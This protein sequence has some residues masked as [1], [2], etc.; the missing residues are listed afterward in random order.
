MGGG[1]LK[2]IHFQPQ[3]FCAC[4]FLGTKLQMR[5]KHAQEWSKL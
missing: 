4:V 5:K 2:E 1:R 3:K